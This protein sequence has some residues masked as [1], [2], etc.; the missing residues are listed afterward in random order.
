MVLAARDRYVSARLSFFS[1]ISRDS[2]ATHTVSGTAVGLLV[3]RLRG[4]EA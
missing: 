1:G 3:P 4:F 2:D